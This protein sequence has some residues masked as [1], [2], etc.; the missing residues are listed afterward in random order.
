MS[1]TLLLIIGAIVALVVGVGAAVIIINNQAQK[2]APTPTPSAQVQV[3][4]KITVTPQTTSFTASVSASLDVFLN[5]NGVKID[6]FQFIANLDGNASPVVTDSDPNTTGVQIT[7]AQVSGLNPV[8]NSVVT[9]GTAQV[10]RYAMIT[11]NAG[12]PFTTGA[13]VKVATITFIPGSSGTVKLDFNTQNTR[14]NKTGTTEDTLI[15]AASQTFTVSSAVAGAAPVVASPSAAITTTTTKTTVSKTTTAIACDAACLNDN[16][17]TS[18]LSCI[19]N[20]CRNPVCSDNTT[21]LCPGVATTTTSPT[22]K[23]RVTA[24]LDSSL[25]GATPSATPKTVITSKPKTATIAALP[26]SLP[27]SGGVADTILLIAAGLSCMVLA[28]FFMLRTL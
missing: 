22:P 10:I 6:G 24:T 27:K 19:N 12:Q 16:D 14:A 7:P 25:S 4:L 11:Q 13:P 18:G 2:Q 3:P 21:C 17:C 26:K 15:T 8:T 23:P 5:T 1:K 9:Q 20:A 28:A